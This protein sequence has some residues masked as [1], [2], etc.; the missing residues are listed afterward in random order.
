MVTLHDSEK[1]LIGV[2]YRTPSSSSVNNNEFI[3]ALSNIDNYHDCSDL[4][5]MGDF[6]A[7]NVDWNDYTCSDGINSF[8]Y[9]LINATL[10]SYLTQHACNISHPTYFGQRSSILDLVFASN[11]NSIVSMQHYSPLGSSDHECLLFKLKYFTEQS[12]PKDDMCKYNYM[13][14]DYCTISS[15]LD[16]VHWDTLL[17]EQSTDDNWNTFKSIVLAISS[18]YTPKIKKKRV[19]NKPP[20]WSTQISKAVRDKQHLF[21]HYK[22]T[23]SEVVMHRYRILRSDTNTDTSRTILSLTWPIPI[24]PK[25]HNERLDATQV[26]GF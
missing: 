13:K 17:R 21:S 25:V 8:S 19:S 20:W 9:K 1:L 24:P 4:L 10:D 23:C 3:T 7:P 14:A 15:E 12:K 16:K 2:V 11:P 5:I 6:N 18:K 22:Y 26:S